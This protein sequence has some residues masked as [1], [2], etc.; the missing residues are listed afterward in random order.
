MQI[1][2]PKGGRTLKRLLNTREVADYLGK[3]P[4]WVRENISELGIPAIKM[5]RQWRYREEDVE[6]WLNLNRVA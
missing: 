3:S 5:G 6:A 2:I 1:N 4:W